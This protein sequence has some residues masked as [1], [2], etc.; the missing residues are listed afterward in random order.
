VA[1]HVFCSNQKCKKKV[2]FKKFERPEIC[3]FCQK[4][5]SLKP[6]DEYL[7]LTYQD[8]YFESKRDIRYMS[9][10]YDILLPYTTKTILKKIKNRAFLSKDTLDDR[11][12]EVIVKILESYNKNDSFKIDTSFGAYI[13][14]VSRGVLFNPKQVNIDQTL[15]INEKISSNDNNNEFLDKM[16][17]SESCTIKFRSNSMSDTAFRSNDHILEY[18]ER[19]LNQFVINVRKKYGIKA[20]LEFLKGFEFMLDKKRDSFMTRYFTYTNECV[21][22][23][24][25]TMSFMLFTFLEKG[26]FVD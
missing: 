16:I 19:L 26:D 18:I 7:L 9:K 2:E 13:E 20:S 12:N 25:D 22:D 6:M 21:R 10:M 5:H 17:K 1:N 14:T 23:V 24:L 15:S 3:P 4:K 11:V 8:K